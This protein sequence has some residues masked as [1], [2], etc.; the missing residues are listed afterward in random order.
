VVN[1]TRSGKHFKP[2]FLEKDHLGRNMGEGSR[3]LG[4]NGNE[5]KEEDRL[6][7]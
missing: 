1:I 3:P 4:L 6:L 2:L 7:A 5:E